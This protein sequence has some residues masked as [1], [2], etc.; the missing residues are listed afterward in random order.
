MTYVIAAPCIAIYYDDDLPAPLVP[1][2]AD[3]ADF[4]AKRLP[5]LDAP[6]GSPGAPPALGRSRPTRH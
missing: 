4:F 5:G 2:L 6:L 1:Y 3:N